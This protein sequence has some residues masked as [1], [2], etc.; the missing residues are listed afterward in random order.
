MCI[1]FVALHQHPKYPIIVIANRDEF[2]VR[3]TKTADDDWL[4]SGDIIAGRDIQAGGTWF[5]VTMS[6]KFAALTNCRNPKD[7]SL[8]STHTSRGQ[9]VIDYLKGDEDP[10]TYLSKISQNAADYL[11]YNIVVSNKD[12]FAY[13]SN[14]KNHPQLLENGKI[15]GISNASLDTPWPKVTRGKEM[16]S[17]YLHSTQNNNIDINK[18]FLILQDDHKPPATELPNTGVGEPWETLLSSIFVSTPFE[19]GTRCSSVYLVDVDRHATFVERSYMPD[20]SWKDRT[21]EFE[22]V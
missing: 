4:S 13:Y 19:Y 16:L 10:M 3:P 7:A 11:G 2:F 8:I 18:L 22:C 5:G 9:L 15:Y 20:G 14:V 6:G 12:N 21:F 1:I 17:T